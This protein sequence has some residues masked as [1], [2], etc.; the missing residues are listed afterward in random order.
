MPN[1]GVSPIHPGKERRK[2][3][4]VPLLVRV[5]CKTAQTY[6]LGHCE[7]ISETGMLIKTQQTFE[8]SQ[9]ATLRFVLPPVGTTGGAVQTGGL[10]VRAQK[11]EYMAVEFIGLRPPYRDAIAKHIEQRKNAPVLTA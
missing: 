9:A 3:H 6:A 8:V 5:E 1:V 7:N 11:G 2:A 4:R 10:V